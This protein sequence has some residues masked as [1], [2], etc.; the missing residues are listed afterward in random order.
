[1]FTIMAIKVLINYNF[2]NIML[3]PTSLFSS[4]PIKYNNFSKKKM[5]EKNLIK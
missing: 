1:M 2:H 5:Y 4:T 3:N